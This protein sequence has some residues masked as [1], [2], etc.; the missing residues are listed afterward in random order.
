MFQVCEAKIK[1]KERIIVLNTI[2]GAKN[3]PNILYRATN[4]CD[5]IK[6]DLVG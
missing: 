3:H 6:G 5:K 1:K 2:N 4:V